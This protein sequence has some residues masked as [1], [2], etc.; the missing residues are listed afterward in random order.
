MAR[1]TQAR[2]KRPNWFARL[3]E[4]FTK[5]AHP[6]ASN[7]RWILMGLLAA[8]WL[9]FGIMGWLVAEGKPTFD[10]LY[11]VL[12]TLTVQGS[13][14]AVQEQG[15]SVFIQLSRWFGVSVP[16]IGVILGFSGQVGDALARLFLTGARHHIVIIG[17]SDAALTL[18]RKVAENP[19]TV[20]VLVASTVP[21][22]DVRAL[23]SQGVVVIEGPPD[24]AKVLKRAGADE[25]G[26]VVVLMD[27]DTAN[28]KAAAAAR[29]AATAKKGWSVFGRK[30]LPIIHLQIEEPVLLAEAREF[31]ALLGA[32]GT[33]KEPQQETRPFSLSEIVARQFLRHHLILPDAARLKQDRPHLVVIGGD[34]RALAVAR[35]ALMVLWS[36]HFQAPRVT[37]LASDETAC[38]NHFSVIHPQAR[39]HAVWSADIDIKTFDW[40]DNKNP[41]RLL[42][43]VETERGPVS[44]VVTA[45]GTDT[46]TIAFTM[47]LRRAMASRGFWTGASIYA[48]QTSTNVFSQSL[49][50]EPEAAGL[51][52]IVPFGALDELVTIG[53]VIAADLDQAA[54]KLHQAYQEGVNDRAFGQAALELMTGEE[55][56][57]LKDQSGKVADDI[58]L[59]EIS[60]RLRSEGISLGRIRKLSREAT[61]AAKDAKSGNLDLDIVAADWSTLPES[62]R[63][64][65]RVSA[66]H[67]LV[68][69]WDAGWVRAKTRGDGQADIKPPSDEA[70]LA[71]MARVE[72]D[73]WMVERLMGGWRPTAID[74]LTGKLEET[75][76]KARIHANLVPWDQIG[77]D[78]RAKDRDQVLAAFGI[79][80]AMSP[81]GFVR[82]TTDRPSP[83]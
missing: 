55:R 26:H 21:A 44:A 33:G 11:T 25:A 42:E 63:K 48:A 82:D 22:S 36:V 4:W 9:G 29:T 38:D 8:L 66:D 20:G 67:S 52:R 32:G 64:S 1:A 68:K 78:D 70:I 46:D 24:D 30:P 49:Q 65:N 6:R 43:D 16:L 7:G 71:E 31:D 23:R 77:P 69:L 51:A 14:E 3:A 56:A 74:P 45:M 59:K 17:A 47:S 40:R 54:A 10:A 80:A 41:W 2:T 28:L 34:D 35:R 13:H 50:A 73:R 60:E 61:Q 12:G 53:M 18:A 62:M 83:A 81:E 39:Q 37:L 79:A 72:H 27:D 76:R 57:A 75:D 58:G 19:E 15:K 5:W